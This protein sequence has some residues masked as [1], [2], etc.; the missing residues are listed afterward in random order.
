MPSFWEVGLRCKSAVTQD[1]EGTWAEFNSVKLYTMAK[2]N[3][4]M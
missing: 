1:E 2:A 4:L 3:N